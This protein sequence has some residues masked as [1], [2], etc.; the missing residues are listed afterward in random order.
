MS[1]RKVD[2]MLYINH[3]PLSQ[4]PAHCGGQVLLNFF[5]KAGIKPKGI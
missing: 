5:E 2:L 1:A 4:R 3:P